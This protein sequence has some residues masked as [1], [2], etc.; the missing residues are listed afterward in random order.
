MGCTDDHLVN[1]DTQ[2]P[3]VHGRGVPVCIDDFG[4]DIFFLTQVSR[5]ET[6]VAWK[7]KVSQTFS[8]HERIGPEVSC[9]GARINQ[10]YLNQFNHPIVSSLEHK[11]DGGNHSYAVRFRLMDSRWPS[12]RLT[13]LFRQIK[14]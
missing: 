6:C 12:A 7:W 10:G 1:Q 11:T 9:T 5:L 8:P 4:G 14:V 13:R 3:P 2:C